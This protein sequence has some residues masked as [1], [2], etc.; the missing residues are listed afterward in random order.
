MTL[1]MILG[2]VGLALVDSTSLGTLVL[3][4]A[5]LSHDR[6]RPGRMLLYLGSIAVF[7]WVLG[8]GLLLG[9][10]FLVKLWEGWADTDTASWVALVIGVLMLAGSFWPDT[11]WAKRRRAAQSGGGRRTQWQE[12]LVGDGSRPRTVIVVAVAAG[13]VEA[14]SMLPY[15]G[16]I[17]I[18]TSS[19]L[20]LPVSLVTLTGYVLVMVAP[21]LALLGLRMALDTRISPLLARVN[22]FL[23]RHTS[24]AVWWI[25]GIIGF[26]LAADSATRLGLFGG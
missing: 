25:V 8:V 23:A 2:L 18:I 10:G 5:M 15:L 3:P 4:L 14:A 17:G 6:V 7:Y 21:A 11:P 12:R 26:F 19:G 16:A 24:G 20:G 22:G 13:L 9:A 1:A